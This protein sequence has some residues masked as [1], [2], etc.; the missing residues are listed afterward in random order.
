MQPGFME[1]LEDVLPLIFSH[2]SPTAL[3]ACECTC[4]TFRSVCAM[5]NH[6]LWKKYVPITLLESPLARDNA[7]G[8][9]KRMAMSILTVPRILLCQ[10]SSN[11]AV[12][13]PITTP[14]VCDLS[15]KTHSPPSFQTR[16]RPPSDA[17]PVSMLVQNASARSAFDG[18][19]VFSSVRVS[20]ETASACGKFCAFLQTEG[21]NSSPEERLVLIELQPGAGSHRPVGS[22]R[23]VSMPGGVFAM[24]FTADSS[25]LLMVQDSQHRSRVF[26]LHVPSFLRSPVLS[27]VSIRDA[28][29]AA[30]LCE[31]SSCA[32]DCSPWVRDCLV[33]VTC[34][35]KLLLINL[36]FSNSSITARVV[37]RFS[38]CRP[39]FAPQVAADAVLFLRAGGLWR[40]DRANEWGGTVVAVGPEGV[41]SATR[42]GRYVAIKREGHGVR[43]PR[44]AFLCRAVLLN[45]RADCSSEARTAHCAP[46]S[47]SRR[48]LLARGLLYH[49]VASANVASSRHAFSRVGHVRPVPWP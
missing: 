24:A 13:L 20:H 38:Q 23:G 32:F 12:T 46:V 4:R 41:F 25:F 42:D 35:T 49:A 5:G 48:F 11:I 10:H 34:D 22:S 26:A 14:R 33:A 6:V 15:A 47:Y 28:A 37:R 16:S 44:R 27:D 30:L 9:Y 3:A 40:V 39:G 19:P 17:P 18:S 31:G 1:T 2:L 21:A 45:E 7:E 43:R 8:N 36:V 29:F